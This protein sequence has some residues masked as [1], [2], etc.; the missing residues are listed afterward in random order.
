MLAPYLNV[1][2]QWIL[3]HQNCGKHICMYD[4]EVGIAMW[5]KK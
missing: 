4:G 3:C 2:F 1:N 5:N